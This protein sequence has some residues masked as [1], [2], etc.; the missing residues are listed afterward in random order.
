MNATKNSIA[1]ANL[2]LPDDEKAEEVTRAFQAFIM[3]PL[4]KVSL[5]MEGLQAELKNRDDRINQLEARV[6]ALEAK[7]DEICLKLKQI[8]HIFI[9]KKILG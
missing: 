7:Y 9:L 8:E 3:E 2:R 1:E 6:K 5:K 4:E